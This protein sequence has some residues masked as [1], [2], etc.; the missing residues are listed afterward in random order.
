[1]GLPELQIKEIGMRM[2]ITVTLAEPILTSAAKNGRVESQ[3]ESRP[4]SQ[5]ES[6]RVRIIR[7][8]EDGALSKS[9]ISNRLGQKLISG[10]LNKVLKALLEEGIVEYTIPDKPNS[11]LQKY[12][13]K[14]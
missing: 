8:I 1:M 9:E 6:L 2:R 4:E 3:P 10:Q 7:L 12:R 11:R 13:I 5:P 14:V